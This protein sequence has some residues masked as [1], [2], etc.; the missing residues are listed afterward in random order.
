MDGR[1]VHNT[2]ASG[3][4]QTVAFTLQ[5]DLKRTMLLESNQGQMIGDHLHY[6]IVELVIW[7]RRPALFLS[8]YRRL[9]LIFRVDRSDLQPG[10]ANQVPGR[11]IGVAFFME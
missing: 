2:Y 3:A 5:R 10:R 11:T 4:D 8:R 9:C 7:R 1:A 6:R